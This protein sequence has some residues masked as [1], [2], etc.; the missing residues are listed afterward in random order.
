MKKFKIVRTLMPK[1]HNEDRELEERISILSGY[2]LI[3]VEQ[4]FKRC[5]LLFILQ[6]TESD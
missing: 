1:N 3:T 6:K 4:D 5:E 2:R